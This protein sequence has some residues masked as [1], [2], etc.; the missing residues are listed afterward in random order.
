MSSLLIPDVDTVRA[1]SPAD[2]EALARELDG[3]RR[4]AESALALVV[5]RVEEVGA[6]RRDG[7]RGARAWGMA[8]CNWSL[9]EAAR[10]VKAGHLLQRFSSA[11]GMGVAQLHALAVVAANPRVQPHLDEAEE[12]LVGQAAVLDF[13]DY[14][15]LLRAWEA[16]ADPDGAHLDHERAHREREASL[17]QVG[18]KSFLNAHGGAVAGAQ[19]REILDAFAHSEF[20][21]DWETG[22]AEHGEAMSASRM[23]RTERQ[24]RFDALVAIFTAAAASGVL[25]ASQ[26]TVNVFCDQAVLEHAVVTALGGSAEPLDPSVPHRCETSH[27]VQLDPLDV[28]IA[29]ALG[30]VRRVVLDSAGV[31]IDIGRKQRLFTGA[32]REV[33]LALERH[34]FGPGCHHP[35]R[36]VDHVLPWARG[37]LTD[38]ANAGPACGHHNRWRTRGYTTWRD[39]DGHWHHQRPDGTEIGWRSALPVAGS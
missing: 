25:G 22:R 31:V 24:R 11:S 15:V 14:S 17:A 21:A 5:A 12:L 38:P 4:A 18:V 23:V 28:L 1:M 27:G 37:G 32:L 6:F 19:L 33:L 8:A 20:L 2:L 9:P 7:H 30:H 16:A 29:A 3:V 13:E 39:A 36:Q 35:P 10:F 34:C 26:P